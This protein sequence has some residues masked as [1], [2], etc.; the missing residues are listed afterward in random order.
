MESEKDKWTGE[1]EVRPLAAYTTNLSVVLDGKVW[2]NIYGWCR[3]T[4][5]ECSGMGLV[6]KD[7]GTFRVYEAFLPEQKCTSV[8]TKITPKGRNDMMVE[9]V[10]RKLPGSDLKFWWHTHSDFKTFWSV[11]DVKNVDTLV[12]NKDGWLLSM[13]INQHGDYECRLDFTNPIRVGI[14]DISVAV[15]RPRTRSSRQHKQDIQKMVTVEALPSIAGMFPR[16]NKMRGISDEDDGLVPTFGRGGVYVY[17]DGNLVR[18]HDDER[19]ALLA[20]ESEEGMISDD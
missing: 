11:T 17:K 2:D 7:G 12:Q 8:G 10:K 13:V 15:D 20:L 6:K 18:Q 5:S 1:D 14:E 16:Y 19:S 3:A 9:I 4:K